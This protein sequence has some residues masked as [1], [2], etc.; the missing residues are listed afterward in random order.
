MQHVHEPNQPHTDGI[1]GP[2]GASARVYLCGQC[3]CNRPHDIRLG[4][5]A[6]YLRRLVRGSLTTVSGR[7]PPIGQRQPIASITS[8]QAALSAATASASPFGSNAGVAIAV[9]TTARRPCKSKT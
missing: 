1:A 3:G 4:V 2:Y 6:S 9:A 5:S 7:E 8:R